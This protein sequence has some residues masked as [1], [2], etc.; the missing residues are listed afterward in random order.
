MTKLELQKKLAKLS[1]EELQSLLFKAKKSQGRLHKAYSYTPHKV[2]AEFHASDARIRLVQ[3]SNRGGK[4]VAGWM[5]CF[6]WCLGKHPNFDI[7]TPVRGRIATTSFEKG[8]KQIIIPKIE[9]WCPPELIKSWGKNSQ[10]QINS[11]TFTNGSYMDF[12]SYQQ[13]FDKYEGVDL[14]FF[15]CD[16]APPRDIYYSLLTRIIDRAGCG[17]ITMSPLKE[18]W[19]YDE[20]WEPTVSGEKKDVACFSM[21]MQDNPYLPKDMVQF[22]IE[23]LPEDEREARVYGKWSHLTAKILKEFDRAVHVCEPFEI[24]H[25]WRLYEV[26]DPHPAKAHAII[27]CMISPDNMIYVVKEASFLGTIGALGDFV[28]RERP[29]PRNPDTIIVDTSTV[30]KSNKMTEAMSPVNLQQLLTNKIGV[31]LKAIKEPE[32][33]IDLLRQRLENTVKYEKAT[34][35]DR[36]PWNHRGIKFFSSCK[37][38]IRQVES[39]IYDNYLHNSRTRDENKVKPVKRNDDFAD[40]VRYIATMDPNYQSKWTTMRIE[41]LHKTLGKKNYKPHR[42]LAD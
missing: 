38:T 5:E 42:S 36:D 9:E 30:L 41:N 33:G 3:G 40:C 20:I 26:I 7:R 31:F 12:M 24:P 18:P 15:W 21:F 11:I 13:T 10:G 29:I 19:I 1:D 16:E 14:D 27:W 22:T 6:Y 34:E 28:R 4:T 39:W 35:E 37:H 32:A 25:S 8:L 23:Q 17:W 2:Q